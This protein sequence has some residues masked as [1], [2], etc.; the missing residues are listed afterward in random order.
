MKT[1]L[2]KL[3][4]NHIFNVKIK[5]GVQ[6]LFLA[7]H[8]FFAEY[9]HSEV[10]KNGLICYCSTSRSCTKYF[11]SCGDFV[12]L[13]F[14]FSVHQ[15]PEFHDIVTALSQL[16]AGSRHATIAKKTIFG[17]FRI[18]WA[19]KKKVCSL[20]T[21]SLRMSIFVQCV[22]VWQIF[23]VY[24]WKIRRSPLSSETLL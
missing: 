19:I 15:C 5:L 2:T 3:W 12:I 1:V 24:F 6:C 18:V 4:N 7:K 10:F 23:V 22:N 16:C 20:K 21:V 9:P 17:N 13:L 11:Q 8:R 14:M